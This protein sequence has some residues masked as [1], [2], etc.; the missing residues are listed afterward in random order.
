MTMRAKWKR[1]KSKAK[2]QAVDRSLHPVVQIPNDLDRYIPG[3]GCQCE[4]WSENECGCVGVDWTPK[5]VY[6]QRKRVLIATEALMRLA[7]CDWVITLPDRM[8]AV[9]KIARD[10]LAEIGNLNLSRQPPAAER[11][12]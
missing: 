2:R 9:R 8:D 4:A 1:A 3:H 6:V 7:N 5:E 11:P 12:E 10:A